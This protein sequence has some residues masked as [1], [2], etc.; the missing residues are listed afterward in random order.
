MSVVW[1]FKSREELVETLEWK[2][3]VLEPIN[4]EQRIALRDF[5][6]RSFNL[7]HSVSELG[8]SAARAAIRQDDDFLVPDWTQPINVGALEI[9]SD[10]DPILKPSY[11]YGFE[12]GA[13]VLIW[14]S[15][16]EFEAVTVDHI[17]SNDGLILSNVSNV[18][19]RAKLYPLLSCKP[20]SQLNGRLLGKRRA[21]MQIQFTSYLSADIAA[22]SYSQYRT[23][24]VVSECPVLGGGALSQSIAN[25]FLTFDAGFGEPYN[26]RARGF[27]DLLFTMRWHFST[28]QSVY[29]FKKWLYSIKGRLTAFWISTRQQDLE[30]AA[31]ISS[32]GTTVTVFDF[33]GLSLLG[34]DSG[35]DID[36]TSTAGA[37]YYRQVTS[38]VA[39][40]PVNGRATVNMT[41]SSSLGVQLTTG[42]IK[43]IS[44][45]RCARLESDSIQITHRAN[46]GARSQVLCREVPFPS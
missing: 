19:S 28:K 18:Y 17:D 15:E 34:R 40:T 11:Y 46:A 30:P 23:L 31:T 20:T 24:D 14:Q 44:F 13:N 41:I 22:S 29:I 43:R 12:E 6:R 10:S 32:G 37:S 36:I 1:P 33:P 8:L 42:N 35:F 3:D 9:K 2:T 26:K 27:V 39:G 21:E 4:R 25:D 45:L 38:F 5:P 7:S 16:S